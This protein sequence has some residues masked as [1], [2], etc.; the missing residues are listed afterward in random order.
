MKTIIENLNPTP[1]AFADVYEENDLWIKIVGC[2]G[3]KATARCCGNCKFVTSKGCF[4]HV[5]SRG[6]NKPLYCV[7]KPFPVDHW[8]YCQ[9]QFKCVKG[10]NKGKI[11][12]VK[13]QTGLLI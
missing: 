2:K 3:C 7:I 4:W 5:D 13:D 10:K 12:R 1:I 11:R 8:P 6:Q 9:Q